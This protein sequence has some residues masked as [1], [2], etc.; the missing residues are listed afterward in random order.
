MT[1]SVFIALNNLARARKVRVVPGES[2]SQ[3]R[4]DS[5]TKSESCPGPLLLMLPPAVRGVCG[6][7]I[8]DTVP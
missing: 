8:T 5:K 4:V 2:D 7:R 3:I 6:Q 1:R